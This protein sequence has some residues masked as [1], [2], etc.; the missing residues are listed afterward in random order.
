MTTLIRSH[1]CN[2]GKKLLKSEPS[3]ISYF[4]NWWCNGVYPFN[5]SQTSHVQ[6]FSVGYEYSRFYSV[7]NLPFFVSSFA[8]M[9]IVMQECRR[10]TIFAYAK[11]ATRT[12]SYGAPKSLDYSACTTFNRCTNTGRGVLCFDATV[13]SIYFLLTSVMRRRPSFCS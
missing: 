7:Y 12:C 1:I 10:Q 11:S 6:S 9:Y 13:L 3:I 8:S 2:K 5:T 4:C